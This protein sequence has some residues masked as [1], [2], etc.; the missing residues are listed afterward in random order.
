VHCIEIAKQDVE[1]LLKPSMASTT[2]SNM[3]DNEID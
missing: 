2:G 1:K 3:Q